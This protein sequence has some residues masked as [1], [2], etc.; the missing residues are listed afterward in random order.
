MADEAIERSRKRER[1]T[2]GALASLAR[3]LDKLRGRVGFLERNAEA[4]SALDASAIVSG[5]I[6]LERGG[7]G[8]SAVDIAALKAA[9][10]LPF[11]FAAGELGGVTGWTTVT[12]P[13]DTF[14]L[15]PLV[16]AQQ[17][18]GAGGA[19]GQNAMVTN[20]T[21]TQ[22]IMRISGATAAGIHWHATQMKDG[23]AAG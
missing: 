20:V 16:T 1:Q 19:I 5:V 6:P 7:T 2:S 18:S 23:S 4:T 15:P 8:I 10:G 9:L 14:T 22:C 21:V 13:V 17:Y 3:N 11:G 12:W